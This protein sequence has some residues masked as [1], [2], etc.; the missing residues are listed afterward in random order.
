MTPLG[1]GFDDQGLVD[2]HFG[3]KGPAKHPEVIEIL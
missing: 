1:I 3:C 2:K